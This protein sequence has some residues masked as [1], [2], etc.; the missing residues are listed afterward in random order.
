MKKFHFS[1]Q[2]V[3]EVKQTEE[4]GLQRNLS[5]AEHTLLEAEK[6]LLNKQNLLTLEL[7]KLSELNKE[8]CSATDYIL[9]NRYVEA[10]ENQIKNQNT[11]IEYFAENVKKCRKK[12]MEKARER[13]IIEKL[14]ENKLKEYNRQLKKEEQL[15]L[16]E[17]SAQNSHYKDAR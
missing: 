3:M 17:I 12:L 8:C 1:L 13:K 14:R 5:I 11:K 2:K 6:V 16:D 4:K 7:N 15:F 9:H 10:L